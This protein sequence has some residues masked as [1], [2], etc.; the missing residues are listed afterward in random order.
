M[1]QF[2][3]GLDLN[4]RFY[5]DIVRPFLAG[6]F[7]GLKYTAARIGQGSEVLGFD[8]PMSTDHDWGMRL[9][10]FL[11]REDYQ[12]YGGVLHERLRHTLPKSYFGYPTNFSEADE[13]GSRLMVETDVLVNHRL[14]IWTIH[15]FLHDHMAWDSSNEPT[16]FDWLTWPQQLLLGITAGA[17]YSDQLGELSAIRQK[18]RYY[19]HDL[20]LYL[21]AAQWARIGQ[22]EH[23][24]GRTGY[25]D[26]DLGSR[27]LAARLVHDLMNL[28][29]L[30]ERRYA[31]YPKWFGTAFNRLVCAPNL[32]PILKDVLQAKNWHDREDALCHA[33]EY[34]AHKHNALNITDPLPAEVEFF[35]DR[36]FRVINADRFVT[37]LKEQI[38]DQQVKQIGTDIGSIDQFSHSTDLRSYP[39]LHRRLHVLYT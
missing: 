8:T 26:D 33:Y 18:L 10:I 13:E 28:C 2:I 17:V 14:E 30:M 39:R 24:V 5:N 27:I 36:P 37:A 11:A 23:F 12:E 31:P 6:E 3:P 20:W 34:V 9:Q 4:R 19:P 38:T 32:V 21:L 1:T 7:P 22:E 15:E 35:H 16:I 29:F 25:L